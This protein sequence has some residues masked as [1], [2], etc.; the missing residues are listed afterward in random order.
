MLNK[1][2]SESIKKFFPHTPTDLQL[3]FF[4][5]ISNYLLD[6]NSNKV[7]IL[8]GY[9]GTGKTSA[10]AAL[11]KA[12]KK[13]KMKIILLAPTGRAAKVFS[14]FANTPTWTIHKH[15]Y[16]QKSDEDGMGDFVLNFNKARNTLF[17]I[18]EASMLSDEDTYSPF[19]SGRLLTDVF[20]FIFET[21]NNNKLLLVGDTAQLP[22]VGLELGHA[23]DASYIYETFHYSVEE[24]TLKEVIRQEFDSGILENATSL[25]KK[26][27][28]NETDTLKLSES[29]DVMHITGGELIER[30]SDSYSK[31]GVE[32]TIVITRS[33][34][35]ANG[36][37][38]GIRKTILYRED[39][40][41][42]GDYL[43]V[44]KNNYYWKDDEA[45]LEFIAN[46]EIAEITAF[47]RIEELYGFRF[48]E[49]SLRFV[50]Y[51][52]EIETKIL[53]DTLTSQSPALSREEN[54]QLYLN[55][56]EDYADLTNKK[57][58]QKAMRENPYFNAL[59]VKFA[60]AI[61]CHKSQGGQWDV[62][63][64]DQGYLTDDMLGDDYY[65]WLYT[66]VTRAKKKLFFVNFQ[67][68]YRTTTAS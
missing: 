43:M 38:E 16:R 24:I 19:G 21:G 56:L 53:L 11:V 61:T 62:V 45:K 18:D 40:V 15:I 49:V 36:Y 60:Y 7:F 44:V 57:K 6:R 68:K 25:R 63:F 12:M 5:R 22:P 30:L 66:A 55:V 33:N 4:D 58:R 54:K 23:L 41:A 48:A 35:R 2:I 46:G 20:R 47:K 50:N 42:V 27:T 8:K 52:I 17:I 51:D 64:V 67:E 34:K 32:E 65:R 14:G 29:F 10:V 1:Y 28:A 59:Q 26:L 39:E 31:E 37:N 9:A 13:Q 3:D